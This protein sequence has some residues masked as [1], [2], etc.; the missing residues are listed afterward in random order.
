MVCASWKTTPAVRLHLT[1]SSKFLQ[2][3]FMP[4][5]TPQQKLVRFRFFGEIAPQ[6]GRRYLD[7]SRQAAQ[8]P[9]EY[10]IVPLLILLYPLMFKLVV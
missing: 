6:I 3:S 8:A 9:Y 5:P 10:K 4:L 1:L 7:A 2:Q